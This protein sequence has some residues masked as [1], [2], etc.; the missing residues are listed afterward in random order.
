MAL[1]LRQSSAKL[2]LDHAE[3]HARKYRIKRRILDN[4]G[5]TGRLDAE[6]SASIQKVQ[7]LTFAGSGSPVN[8]RVEEMLKAVAANAAAWRSVQKDVPMRSQSS[9]L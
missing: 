8:Y 5:C 9:K 7:A 1:A 2:L 3:L 4:D 6:L